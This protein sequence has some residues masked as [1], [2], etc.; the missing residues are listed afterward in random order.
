VVS[1]AGQ[2][3]QQPIRERV[4]E[5]VRTI[6]QGG[7]TRADLDT[8]LNGL[9]AQFARELTAATANVSPPTAPV[10]PQIAG[11]GTTVIYSS[12]PAAQRI[13]NLSGTELFN[14]TVDGVSGLTDADIPDAITASNY[15]PLS[16]GSITGDLSLSGTLTAR[17]TRRECHLLRRRR[18]SS[19][20]QRNFINSNLHIFRRHFSPWTR[21]IYKFQQLLRPHLVWCDWHDHDRNERHN[22]DALDHCEF[23]N[24]V[25]ASLYSA[26]IGSLTATSS[27][28]ATNASTTLLPG[29]RSP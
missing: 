7:I 4:R 28:L 26:S 1:F 8:A 18:R 13:D 2:E 21:P 3:V 15:L 10:P 11:G 19:L 17:R 23:R 20:L 14:I 25:S 12:S 9:R 22:F 16:G 6:V 27:L 5:T 29:A 24:A